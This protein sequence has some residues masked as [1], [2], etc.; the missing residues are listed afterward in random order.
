VNR[1]TLL[2]GVGAALVVLLVW[3]FLLWS[4]R[5]SAIDKAKSRQ[6]AAENQASSLQARLN[7]LRDAQRNEAA[8]RAQ[9]AQLQEAI[10]DEANLAQFILDANDAAT[11]SGIDFLSISPTPPAGGTV[12]GAV[13][14]STGQ[15]ATPAP[16]SISLNVSIAGGYF[17]LLDFVNRLTDLPRIVVIDGLTVNGAAGTDLAVQLTGRMFTS[18]PPAGSTPTTTTTAPGAT[19]TTTPGVTTTAPGAT[20]TVAQ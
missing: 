17:Q 13:D 6:A 11:R 20:T 3:Y 19:T 7:Q 2:I 15:P 5:G 4:P 8:T 14:P 9:I 18:Q 1:R 12:S 16:S 10:P